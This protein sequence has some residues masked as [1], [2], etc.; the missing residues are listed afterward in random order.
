[1]TL[2]DRKCRDCGHE[3]TNLLKATTFLATGYC[4]QCR[5]KLR[6][7]RGCK[8]EFSEFLRA[9]EAK[10][11]HLR[12]LCATCRDKPEY[13]CAIDNELFNRVPVPASEPTYTIPGTLARISVYADRYDRGEEIFH[14]GD[15]PLAMS[16][17]IWLEQY[18]DED[19]D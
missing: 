19:E 18:N 4:Y 16:I 14:D 11:F 10:A 2:I 13:R 3:H 8:R 9:R 5:D 6:A 17:A 7:C 1:M 12:G 15:N